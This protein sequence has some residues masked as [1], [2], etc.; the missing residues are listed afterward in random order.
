VQIAG[1]LA[2]PLGF[3]A[4]AITTLTTN[5]GYYLQQF[6]GIL[7]WLDTPLPIWHV[8]GYA[9]ALM[10]IV[11]FGR[12]SGDGQ[13]RDLRP[14]RK[15]DRI[16]AIVALVSSIALLCVLA[17]LWNI[18]G[19]DRIG[20]IQGRYFIP[21]APLLLPIFG[22]SRSVLKLRSLMTGAI[23]LAI[24]SGVSTITVL[25]QRYYAIAA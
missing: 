3:V 10:L 5:A 22:R 24:V 14:W 23:G 19:V 9:I 16:I 13:D 4:I 20:G 25:V 8:A 6:I 15:R 21:L 1:I 2:D 18:V 12:S 17:Y 7:G 11:M